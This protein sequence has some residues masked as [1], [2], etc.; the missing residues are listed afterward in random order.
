M[1]ESESGTSKHRV[2]QVGHTSNIMTVARDALIIL[3]LAVLGGDVVGMAVGASAN[4][5]RARIAAV[6]TIVLCGIVGFFISGY[7]TPRRR[8]VHLLRVTACVWLF[9]CVVLLAMAHVDVARPGIPIGACVLSGVFA[10]VAMGI[11]G[12]LSFA[13]K[14]DPGDPPARS[15]SAQPSTRTTWAGT[16]A[17]VRMNWLKIATMLSSTLFFVV[18]CTGIELA[19]I[20]VRKHV[21]GH[22]MARGEAPDRNLIVIASIPIPAVPGDRKVE[23]VTLGLLPRFQSEHPDHSFLIPAR[24][25]EI[26]GNGTLIS[27]RAI[28][29]D[30]GNVRVETDAHYPDAFDLRVVGSYEATEREVRPIYTNATNFFENYIVGIAGACTLGLIGSILKWVLRRRQ[31]RDAPVE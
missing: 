20:S 21:G 18:S 12:A 3:A 25:G 29:L 14:K 22:Y 1:G 23:A 26:D 27:Y 16:P 6:A 7:R 10:L 2:I 15:G 24:S 31:R 5:M 28:A 9:I 8:W 11:G 17:E 4:L 19:S 30:S 13:L